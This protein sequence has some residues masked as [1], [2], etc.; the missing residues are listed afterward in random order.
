M[1]YWVFP[2]TCAR[3]KRDSLKAEVVDV[4]ANVPGQVIGNVVLNQS[5]GEFYTRCVAPAAVPLTIGFEP[6]QEE[7]PKVEEG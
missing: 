4:L 2:C 5:Q 3:L 6:R 7:V 1:I